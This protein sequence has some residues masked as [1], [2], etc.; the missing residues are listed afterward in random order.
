MSE[1]IVTESKQTV[2]DAA[3]TEGKAERLSVEPSF[4]FKIGY[5]L[6]DDE[7]EGLVKQKDQKEKTLLWV[8]WSGELRTNNWGFFLEVDG[9]GNASYKGKAS[10]ASQHNITLRIEGT[11]RNSVINLKSYYSD[12]TVLRYTGYYKREGNFVKFMLE[13]IIVEIGSKTT[14][15]FNWKLG[16]IGKC[17]G[18]FTTL[19][20][21]K[22]DHPLEVIPWDDPVTAFHLDD[23]TVSPRSVPQRLPAE[24]FS[25][26]LHSVSHKL[27]LSADFSFCC[28][29]NTD[30]VDRYQ[31]ILSNWSMDSAS[32]MKYAFAL[33]PIAGS[34]QFLIIFRFEARN[35]I[36]LR[37]GNIKPNQWSHVSFTWSRAQKTACLYVDGSKYHEMTVKDFDFDLYQ[38]VP[39]PSPYVAIGSA[40]HCECF[41]QGVLRKLTIYKECVTPFVP[42][43]LYKKQFV[44]RA[45]AKYPRDEADL[46]DKKDWHDNIYVPY[47]VGE[48]FN[49]ISDDYEHWYESFRTKDQLRCLIQKNMFEVEVMNIFD[50]VPEE[51][52][53]EP[54]EG[55]GEEA[56]DGEGW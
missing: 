25:H 15:N 36:F 39:E 11:W 52:K 27:N 54:R 49:I 18:E 38:N 23:G 19:T 6:D 9:D 40:M 44:R 42:Q 50:K 47:N 41:F 10:G 34:Y 8:Q 17:G 22:E 28:Y 33:Q 48:Q 5:D 32:T 21:L 46:P 45:T 30:A 13:R 35:V 43:D 56:V 14:T 4:G 55:P 26:T 29:F 53:K 16:K 24:I 2:A 31:V 20:W 37:A 1:E 51:V 12:N 3:L 7:T